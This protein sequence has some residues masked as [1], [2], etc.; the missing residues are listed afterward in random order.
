[1]LTLSAKT[2]ENKK[3]KA[4]KKE[5]LLPAV[6][7][8]PKIK[9]LSLEIDKKEFEKIYKEAGES[10]LIKLKAE[11]KE[12]LVLIHD[13]QRDPLKGDFLHVDFYQ[14]N[15]EEETEVAVN[16]RRGGPVLCRYGQH[17]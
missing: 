11:S 1:M 2:R 13:F 3:P 8:G 5:G 7:Y 12:F 16:V 9:N 15:L 17:L 10:S 6:L 14:P 4:L